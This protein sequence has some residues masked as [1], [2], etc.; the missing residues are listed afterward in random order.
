MINLGLTTERFFAA[1]EHMQYA[2]ASYTAISDLS[3]YDTVNQG[4]DSLFN[5]FT[6]FSYSQYILDKYNPAAHFVGYALRTNSASGRQEL[7]ARFDQF[8]QDKEAYIEANPK[9]PRSISENLIAQASLNGAGILAS[10][11][12][13]SAF[14]SNPTAQTII[15]W[16]AEQSSK[17]VLGFQPFAWTDFGFCKYYGKIPNNRLITLRRYPFPVGDRLKSPNGADLIPIAQAVTW[18]G[19]ET[20]NKLSKLGNFQWNMPWAEL[21]VT[22]QDIE[23]NEV[24]IDSLVGLLAGSLGENGAKNASALRQIIA[25]ELVK[26]NGQKMAEVTG[27]DVKLKEYVRD[28]YN[29]DK[30]PY[31]NRVYGPVNVID[32][33]TRR[34]RGLQTQYSSPFEINFHY[35]FRSFSGLSPKM[36][37]LDL[38]SNFLQLTYNNAQFLG[39]LSRYFQNTG[40]KFENT[41]TQDITSLLIGW[42]SGTISASDALEKVKNL[43]GGLSKTAL[44]AITT[45]ESG[46]LLKE[47]K[48]TAF[49][50]VSVYAGTKLA[51]AI[52]NLISAKSALSDREIGEWHMVVGN[53]M[54]PIFVMGDLIVTNCVA[55]F[56][57]EIG[58]DDF[59]TG[60]TFTVQLK[61]TKPRDKFAIERMFNS[62]LVGMSFTKI[63]TSSTEDTFSDENDETYK[64][65]YGSSS[66]EERRKAV[67][68]LSVNADGKPTDFAR[69]RD[70][71]GLAYGYREKDSSGVISASPNSR[72]DDSLL[73][74]YFKK[75]FGSQ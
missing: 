16:S 57:E 4:A 27:Y 44:D 31:W 48:K 24:T 69:A 65:A 1:A 72:V 19:N 45:V 49:S 11:S 55:T 70:R 47:L 61:Q 62:G 52:P 58:P 42:A 75:D 46:G 18:F 15:K 6:T 53:P 35:Q 29:K 13:I 73:A 60:I 63:K 2:G 74:I 67:E 59:P 33:S 20:G 43:L 41:V 71:V 23:G 3:T 12:G 9:V 38:I 25:T 39:Q 40:L 66:V 7:A 5:H 34:D 51:E 54:N 26:N 37:A 14:T 30:G 10:A 56:D 17:T 64:K 36:A 28:L 68:Q 8:R 21:Q 32:R 50:A 22:Q